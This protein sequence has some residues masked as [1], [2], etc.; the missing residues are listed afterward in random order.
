MDGYV[1]LIRFGNTYLHKI[2]WSKRHPEEDRRS[3]LQTG[4]PTKLHL[5]G[6]YE[7]DVGAEKLRQAVYSYYKHSEGGT[8]WFDFSRMPTHKYVELMAQFGQGR[9]DISGG[10][11]IS[12]IDYIE[13]KIADLFEGFAKEYPHLSD[14]TSINVRPEF[15][16]TNGKRSLGFVLTLMKGEGP[17]EIL[18]IDSRD[19]DKKGIVQAM[20]DKL[21]S[22]R[23]PL[24]TMR[25]RILGDD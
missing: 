19:I 20:E 25:E 21:T 17:T 11:I 8:E 22:S 2:G 13:K 6:W 10:E 9:S 18:Y 12:R 3:T 14:V 15:H 1:Y 7:G 5:V 16:G 24:D 23:P 4:S